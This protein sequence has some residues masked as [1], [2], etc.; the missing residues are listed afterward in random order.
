MHERVRESFALL[1]LSALVLVLQPG[2]DSGFLPD[3]SGVTGPTEPIVFPCSTENFAKMTFEN[4]SVEGHTYRVI[5]D[6][7]RVRMLEPGEKTGQRQVEFGEHTL[8]FSIKGTGTVACD[9]GTLTLGTC[10]SFLYQCRV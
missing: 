6:G 9:W 3:A 7:E 10:D 8:Y 5:L 2:C 1:L 4:Q